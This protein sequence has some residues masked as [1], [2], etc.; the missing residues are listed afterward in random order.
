MSPLRAGG[1]ENKGKMAKKT[2]GKSAK[3][4]PAQAS[5]AVVVRMSKPARPAAMN[6][7]LTEYQKLLL[8]P[9]NAPLPRS[10]YGGDAGSTIRRGHNVIN[11]S[12]T[13]QLFVFHPIWGVAYSTVAEGTAGSFTFANTSPLGSTYTARALAECVEVMYI[14][15]ETSRSGTVQCG[16]IPGSLV[17]EY[18][19]TGHGGAGLTFDIANVATYLPNIERMPVDKCAVNWFPGNGDG[20]WIPP[21]TLSSGNANTIQRYFADTHFLVVFV[22]GAAANTV[23]LSRTDV[24]EWA[25]TDTQVTGAGFTNMPWLVSPVAVPAQDVKEQVRQLTARDSTWYLNTFKKLA[26]FGFGLASAGITAGLP[27]ALG[28]LTSTIAGAKEYDW[29]KSNRGT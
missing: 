3:K 4:K 10:P 14:G 13:N 15:A 28:Y 24:Y 29:K 19:I 25:S 9:C 20:A 18:T 5:K 8:D 16:V 26:K 11:T 22:A 2:K 17:W 27:G 21:I 7:G 6:S 12:L 23:R 1:A